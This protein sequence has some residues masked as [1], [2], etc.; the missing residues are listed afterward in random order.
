[1][2]LIP[3]CFCRAARLGSAPFEA[4]DDK[5]TEIE[6]RFERLTADLGNPEVI[7]DRTRF[8]QVAKERS[9]LEPLVETFREY[10]GA[11]KHL[12][13]TRRLL[14]DPELRDMTREELPGTEQN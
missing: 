8:S 13:E 6:Q 2:A 4:M 14:D 1:M 11:R 7:G 12:D 5:L 10:K 3:R 9:Q